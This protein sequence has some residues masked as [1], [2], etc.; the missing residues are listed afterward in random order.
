VNEL[1]LKIKIYE[2]MAKNNIR[3]IEELHK[4]AGLSRN[5]I[6]A[7]LNNKKNGLRMG[8]VAKLCRALNCEIGDLIEIKK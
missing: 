3:T 7:L 2:Q 1:E 4:K 5:V 6:S 8:T